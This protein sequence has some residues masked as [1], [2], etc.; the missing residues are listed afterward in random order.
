MRLSQVN[1]LAVV[2]EH[3]KL[4]G[5]LSGSDLRGM[6]HD[7]I[8]TV[9]LPVMEFLKAQHQEGLKSPVTCSKSDTVVSVVKKMLD[10]K[11]HRVWLQNEAGEPTGVISLSDLALFVFTQTLSVWYPPEP[12]QRQ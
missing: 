8:A 9:L 12:E 7:K 10:H 2:D 11:V 1:A 6:S 3:G 5:T 4:V